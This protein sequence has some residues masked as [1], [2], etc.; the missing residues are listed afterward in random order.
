[1]GL[2]NKLFRRPRENMTNDGLFELLT[3]YAPVFSN[4]NENIYEVAL[5]RGAINTFA[6]HCSTLKPE[7]KGEKLSDYAKRWEYKIN[8]FMPTSQ[9]LYRTATI[10]AVKNTVFIIPV[11]DASGSLTGFYPLLP[12]MCEIIESKGELYLRYTFGNGRRAV[13]EFEKV[14][15][16]TSHQFENEFFGTDHQEALKPTLQLIHSQNLSIV[17]GV[18]NSA[19]IRF[20]AKIGNIIK[21]EDI[22]K[23][24]ERF[25]KDN[26]SEDNKS[27]MIIYDNKFADIKQVDSKPLTVNALQMT[28]IKENVYSYFGTNDAI[29]QNKFN[30]NEFNAYFEGKI[31]PFM[32]QLS[33]VLS[34]MAYSMREL[35]QDNGIYFTT[36]R[37]RFASSTTKLDFSTS[38]FDR[39]LLTRNQVMDVWNLPHVEGGDLFYIRKEYAKLE[40]LGRDLD[41]MEVEAGITP[42]GAETTT[43]DTGGAHTEI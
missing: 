30:E 33:L 11:E 12:E 22:T 1:M 37:M 13:I 31:R 3:G 2:F 28:H 17:N 26:L 32:L 41:I 21:T 35:E 25:T 10:F 5:I 42:A 24:R 38:M 15:I 40:D 29:E 39:G 43:P 18:K 14:G 19:T 20:L 27:G 16:L 23:E 36:N 34:I 7:V 9:F 6:T 4:V 8:P